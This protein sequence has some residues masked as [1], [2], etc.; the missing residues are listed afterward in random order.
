MIFDLDRIGGAAALN[1]LVDTVLEAGEQA[2]AMQR[3]IAAGGVERKSDM[4][5]VTAAD[6]AVEELLRGAL[7]R[8]HPEAGFLGEESGEGAQRAAELRFIVDPIDGTRAFIRGLDTWS[9]LVGAEWRDRPVLGIAF[10]PA[11]G[12]LFVAVEGHGATCNGRPLRVSEVER[13]DEALISHGGLEAFGGAGR[14]EQLCRVA[15]RC[16][17]SRGFADFDGYR[18]VLFG[19]ADAMFD[20][21]IEA[22]DICPA[23]VLVREAGGR[24]TCLEGT[25]SIHRGTGLATNGLVHDALLDAW[26]AAEA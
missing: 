9:V 3:A 11:A 17:T 26:R 20:V 18:K 23:A 8:R 14:A 1:A 6:R 13:L 5:P 12:D 22:Y 4:S 10:M 25:D 19:Q 16:F 2:L 21:G 15:A 7:E 24:F